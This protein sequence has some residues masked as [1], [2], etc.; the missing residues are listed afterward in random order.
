MA[1][2]KASQKQKNYPFVLKG[3]N[4]TNIDRMF[5]ITLSSNIEEEKETSVEENTTN[6]LDIISEDAMGS[7]ITGTF[8]DSS[9]NF[10]VHMMNSVNSERIIPDIHCFWCRH[11]FD[12]NPIGCPMQYMPKKLYQKHMSEI[13]G[14]TYIS[15]EKIAD[16]K[17]IE[18]TNIE[19]NYFVTDGVFCSFNCC[20]AYI[21]DHSYDS[22][23]KH[24][25]CLLGKM[26]R[27]I[28]P[29]SK[30]VIRPAPSWKLLTVYGGNMTIEQ[31]R[32]SFALNMY[33]E[34]PYM[35]HRLPKIH[36]IGTIFEQQYIF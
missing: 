28:F 35:L 33:I 16:Y 3:I 23:Y 11:P 8:M 36:P 6:I 20:M 34:K 4:T 5:G 13:T 31:F 14:D 18:W 22:K 1:S 9:K 27:L 32:N 21:N 25:K 26:Y 12:T 17:D 29:D 19:D 24:S 7:Q 15:T 2:K 30:I 10:S